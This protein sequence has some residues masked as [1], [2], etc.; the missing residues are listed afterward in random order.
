MPVR[1]V[2]EMS[3]AKCEWKL[4]PYTQ[5]QRRSRHLDRQGIRTGYLRLLSA[6][7]S[8]DWVQSK[9]CPQELVCRWSQ[10]QRDIVMA[11]KGKPVPLRQRRVVP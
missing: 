4:W 10:A 11:L 2:Q 1:W 8:S 3:C 5:I 7:W 9:V 6:G